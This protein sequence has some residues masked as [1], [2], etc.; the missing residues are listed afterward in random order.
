MVSENGRAGL[1]AGSL[2]LAAG[3]MV[4]IR[5]RKSPHKLGKPD[6]ALSA[7][8]DHYDACVCSS[9]LAQSEAKLM[10]FTH[11]SAG[12]VAGTS[13]AVAAVRAIES[14]NPEPLF[15]DPLAEALAG[16]EP[17]HEIREHIHKIADSPEEAVSARRCSI[18]LH[19][20]CPAALN[21]DG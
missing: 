1:A 7:D 15:V 2:V 20:I 8:Q 11:T 16:P 21:T 12:T 3:L 17:M 5:R 4:A 18:T 10:R 14:Q 9:I 19:C 13:A 6:A